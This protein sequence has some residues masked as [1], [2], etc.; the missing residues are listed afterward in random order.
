MT[1]ASA[2]QP[3]RHCLDSCSQLRL[4]GWST[5]AALTIAINGAPVATIEPDIERSD[6]AQAGIGHGK[7]FSFFLAK[8]LWLDD[9][10]SLQGPDAIPHRARIDARTAGRIAELIRFCDLYR[11]AG[12]EIGPLDRPLIPRDRFRI[13]YADQ[14]S[15]A[16]LTRR[17]Q[18]HN[19]NLSALS[20]PDY[21]LGGGCLQDAVGAARFGY[22]VAS[23]VIEHVPDM[24]GWLWQVWAVLENGAVLSLAIPHAA[25]SFDKHRRLTTL[26]DLVEPYFSRATRP[27]SRHIVDAAL[28]DALYYGKD[29][30]D[31]A[32]EAFHLANHV[33]TA[34]LYWDTHC[35]VLTPGSFTDLMRC[36]DRCGLL[37]FE[38]LD[39]VHPGSDEFFAHL[40]KAG[41][42]T[43]PDLAGS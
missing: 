11:N 13:A 20:D 29:L 43:P 19:L 14:A 36:L 1:G 31:C 15:K 23:H 25:H 27:G 41:S 8:P 3:T 7:G 17:Y 33:R 38:L 30:M 24:I 22:A 4:D 39:V 2:S 28:G 5:A 6:L 26:A 42:K 37:G 18:G 35:S 32:F 16:D 40:R 34:G 10:V 21:V 12:L 9:V